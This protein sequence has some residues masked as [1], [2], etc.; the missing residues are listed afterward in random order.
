MVFTIYGRGSHLG[1]VTWTVWTNFRSPIPWRLHMKFALIG[2]AVSEKKM[3]KKCG[4]QRRTGNGACLYYTSLPNEPKGSGELIISWAGSFE[5]GGFT[6]ESYV[7][8]VA[9]SV[10]P[11]QTTPFAQTC[12]FKNLGSLRLN[13]GS[14]TFIA[15]LLMHKLCLI[16]VRAW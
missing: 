15:K 10:D 4:R 12:L 8:Q 11:D 7:P 1:H 6:T 3:F 13:F 14:Y 16:S 5:Q 2:Q 9:N